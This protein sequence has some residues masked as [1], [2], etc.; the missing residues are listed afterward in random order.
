MRAHAAEIGFI[1]DE[2]MTDDRKNDPM[3]GIPTLSHHMESGKL[4]VP[5]AFQQDRERAEPFLRSLLRW[6]KKPNDRP[7]ALWLAE[8]SVRELIQLER[9]YT[10]SRMPGFEKLPEH[11]R[12]QVTRINLGM[13]S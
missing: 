1:I 3:L 4:S 7:M 5:Y 11:I 10:S 12:K 6:P 9:N 2:W 13:A 8:G